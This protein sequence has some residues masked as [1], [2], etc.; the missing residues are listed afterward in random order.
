MRTHRLPIRDFLWG[1]VVW[2]LVICL[3]PLVFA[4][5]PPRL[6]PTALAGWFVLFVPFLLIAVIGSWVLWISRS[7][8]KTKAKSVLIGVLLGATLPLLFGGG[9]IA[10][11]FNIGF[12]SEG[13]ILFASLLTAATGGLGGAVAGWISSRSK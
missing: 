13:I 7:F 3:E 8:V 10:M 11:D 6:R 12:G 9:L 1:F 5:W 4:F 2:A